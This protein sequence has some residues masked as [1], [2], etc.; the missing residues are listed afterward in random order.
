[1]RPRRDI[2]PAKLRYWYENCGFSTRQIAALLSEPDGRR[3]SGKTVWQ[4]LIWAGVSL[5]EPGPAGP[6]PSRAETR[7]SAEEDAAIRA[8]LAAGGGIQETAAQFGR[9]EGAIARRRPAGQSYQRQLAETAAQLRAARSAQVRAAHAA[10]L[11]GREIDREYGWWHGCARKIQDELGLDPKR[12]AAETPAA[13]ARTCAVCGGPLR[14]SNKIGVCRQTA[15][16]RREVARRRYAA[17]PAKQQAASRTWYARKGK[18]AREEALQQQPQ[19]EACAVCGGSLRRDN[20]LGVCNTTS[21]CVRERRRRSKR[22]A[23][24][25]RLQAAAGTQPVNGPPPRSSE[26]GGAEPTVSQPMGPRRP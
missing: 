19:P 9:S 13:P 4:H 15:D 24:E 6:P 8:A 7:V 20:T 12:P 22:A 16:C 23:R 18:P 14:S 26:K 25:R 11:R 5:R 1:V 17:D 3:V 2:D 10:G 21:E